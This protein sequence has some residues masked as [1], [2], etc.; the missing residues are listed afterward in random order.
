MSAAT[1]TVAPVAISSDAIAG[2]V[3]VVTGSVITSG[4]QF[5]QTH[6]KERGDRRSAVRNVWSEVSHAEA[7]I[8]YAVKNKAGWKVVGEHVKSEMWA[9]YS[10]TLGRDR[11]LKWGSVQAAYIAIDGIRASV[12]IGQPDETF[13]TNALKALGEAIEELRRRGDRPSRWWRPG[14]PLGYDRPSP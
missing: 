4:F 5:F 1:L 9:K 11:K 10:D 12:A 13:V 7:L 6:R 8:A 3:G 2:F 14:N